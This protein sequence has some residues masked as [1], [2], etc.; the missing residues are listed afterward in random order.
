MDDAAEEGECRNLSGIIARKIADSHELNW[1][2]LAL[3]RLADTLYQLGKPTSEKCDESFSDERA[4]R[5][6]LECDAGK[7][8]TFYQRAES[9]QARRYHQQHSQQ[10]QCQQQE[11]R[12]AYSVKVTYI[13]L[14]PLLAVRQGIASAKDLAS[15]SGMAELVS[16][17]N[18]GQPLADAGHI[19]AAA[20]ALGATVVA[21][22]YLQRI[23]VKYEDSC[24]LV[25]AWRCSEYIDG[26]YKALPSEIVRQLPAMEKEFMVADFSEAKLTNSMR[27][28]VAIGACSFDGDYY[29]LHER[30]VI[31]E[32]PGK[33]KY[34]A[35]A[36]P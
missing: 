8:E 9:E 10:Q 4:I 23:D 16:R 20:L 25:L 13:S 27:N 7:R 21:A 15:I 6:T 29:E 19:G 12:T 26:K 34:V 32:R 35:H 1:D 11:K 3:A 33:S 24:A 2:P 28:Q 5:I 22:H 17:L 31:V 14:R 30:I 36:A 18:A